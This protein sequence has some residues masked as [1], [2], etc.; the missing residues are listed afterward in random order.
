MTFI[1]QVSVAVCV[2][3][4]VLL[5]VSV[6][7][8]TH[9]LNHIDFQQ[10]AGEWQVT[11]TLSGTAPVQYHSLTLHQPERLVLDLNDT[12]KNIQKMLKIP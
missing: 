2:V 1:R 6:F 11:L 5:P 10:Q 7:A 8:Q 3:V 4:F 12:S 9:A